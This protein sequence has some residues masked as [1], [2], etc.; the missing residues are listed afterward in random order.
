MPPFSRWPNP[1]QRSLNRCSTD[2]LIQLKRVFSSAKDELKAQMASA[3]IRSGASSLLLAACAGAAGASAYGKGAWMGEWMRAAMG[4]QGEDGSTVAEHLAKLTQDVKNIAHTNNT[5][6]NKG[7]GDGVWTLAAFGAVLGV[8][9]VKMRKLRLDDLM[10]VTQHTFRGGMDCM[11][12][13][14]KSLQGKFECLRTF[15]VES[16]EKL[17]TQQKEI[18]EMQHGLKTDFHNIQQQ[19][20]ELG[21]NLESKQDATLQGVFLLCKM[22]SSS[23]A[24]HERS[25]DA[26]ELQLYLTG[27]GC[28]MDTVRNS[29]TRHKHLPAGRVPPQWPRHHSPCSLEMSPGL[30]NWK[31]LIEEGRRNIVQHVSAS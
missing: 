30:H 26:K 5:S 25:Q 29:C 16:L 3:G 2:A 9:M 6:Y 13:A 24:V 17:E 15:L 11:Q 1:C 28:A 31:V 21:E 27:D 7:S 14:V 4:R 22:V 10:Y 8:A 20:L 19:L 23:Q 12:E 18:N